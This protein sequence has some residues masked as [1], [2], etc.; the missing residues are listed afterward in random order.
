[1]NGA[2]IKRIIIFN[3]GRDAARFAVS[4]QREDIE[5]SWRYIVITDGRPDNCLAKEFRIDIEHP[6]LIFRIGSA[7]VR[8]VSEHQPQ[9]GIAR[10]REIRISITHLKRTEVPGGRSAGI[11]DDP[12]P[13]RLWP[14]RRCH[15]KVIGARGQGGTRG[16]N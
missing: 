2:V 5:V 1:M 13:R 6:V 14:S 4:G 12:N 3:A 9:I 10:A 8:I 16:S 11:P 15:E 7:A